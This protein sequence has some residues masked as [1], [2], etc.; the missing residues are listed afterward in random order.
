LYQK[1]I[2]LK[3]KKPAL[4]WIL[5]IGRYSLTDLSVEVWGSSMLI[6]KAALFFYC[7]K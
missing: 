1:L 3:N 4:D 2:T 6:R 7:F 5:L